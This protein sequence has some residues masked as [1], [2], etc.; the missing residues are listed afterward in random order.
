MCTLAAYV[1]I[2]HVSSEVEEGVG[3]SGI[4]VKDGCRPPC[5]CCGQEQFPSAR[6][7]STFNDRTIATLVCQLFKTKNRNKNLEGV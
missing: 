1:C 4:G 2:A 3:S 7:V 5:G 6:A